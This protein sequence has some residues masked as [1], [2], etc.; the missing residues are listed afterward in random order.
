MSGYSFRLCSL[1]FERNFFFHSSIDEGQLEEETD[2]DFGR[3]FRTHNGGVN[4]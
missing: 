3:L 2:V 4:M 1:V